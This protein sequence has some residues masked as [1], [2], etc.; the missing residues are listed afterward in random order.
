MHSN[1]PRATGGSRRQRGARRGGGRATSGARVAGLAAGGARAAEAVAAA[2]FAR[3]RR[4][5]RCRRRRRRWRAQRARGRARRAGRRTQLEQV[6][7]AAGIGPLTLRSISQSAPSAGERFTSSSHGSSSSSSSTSK[8]V[9]SK[10]ASHSGTAGR[11]RRREDHEVLHAREQ[12]RDAR[13]RVG[14]GSAAPAAARSV[15]CASS[16][17]RS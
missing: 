11:A 16:H 12:P 15:R 13:G 1:V 4:R 17:A 14:A 10:L 5:Y 6:D 8:P 9:S 7:E 2:R 3:A